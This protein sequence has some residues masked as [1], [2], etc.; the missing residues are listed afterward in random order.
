MWFLFTQPCREN[1][2]INKTCIIDGLLIYWIQTTDCTFSDCFQLLSST[3]STPHFQIHVGNVSLFSVFNRPWLTKDK[4]LS[5]RLKWRFQIHLKLQE[6]A[7]N[8]GSVLTGRK[9][10]QT[11]GSEDILPQKI[12]SISGLRFLQNN[13]SKKI[14]RTML[15]GGGGGG[16]LFFVFHPAITFLAVRLWNNKNALTVAVRLACLEIRSRNED[17]ITR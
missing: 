16:V 11:R 17:A 1:N 14:G 6:L 3:Y 12:F 2:L 13:V 15:W 9:V 5:V 7:W 8:L 10:R 4:P